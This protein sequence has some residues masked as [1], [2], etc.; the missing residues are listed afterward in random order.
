MTIL[1][2]RSCMAA[3]TASIARVAAGIEVRGR[4]V[5]EQDLGLERPGARE[6]E[7]L[8]LAAGEHA[9]RPVGE[10]GEPHL[11]ER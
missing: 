1:T 8:L 4:L 6:R 10:M 9:R 7:A 5:Q 3:I 11:R 2:P